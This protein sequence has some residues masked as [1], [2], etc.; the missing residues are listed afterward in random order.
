[1]TG[2]KL[3]KSEKL[4]SKTG[5]DALFAFRG[6][7]AIAFPVRMVW[8]EAPERTRGSR[9]QFL[10]SIPKKRLRHAVDRVA[11]R[12]RIR[13]AYRLNRDLIPDSASPIDVAFIYVSQDLQP[14]RRVESAIRR[15]LPQLPQTDRN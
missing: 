4:C 5:I 3:Y 6:K 7:G 2:L 13:E 8:R 15:L 1:M 11:M 10:I 9:V 14:Y 12:R